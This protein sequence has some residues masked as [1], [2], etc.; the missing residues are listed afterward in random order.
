M[1]PAKAD[2]SFRK[3]LKTRIRERQ[4][5]QCR[6][7]TNVPPQQR[8]AAQAAVRAAAEEPAA[9]VDVAVAAGAVVAAPVAVEVVRAEAVAAAV[10][11]GAV[12][13]MAVPAGRAMARADVMVDVMAGAA[14]A[15][16]SSSRT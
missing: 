16:A 8:G 2:W 10:P 13:A 12:V 11:P 3:W 4:C 15:A 6:Q 1:E 9:P 7:R 14:M 5:R